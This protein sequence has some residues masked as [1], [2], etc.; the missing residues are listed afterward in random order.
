MASILRRTEAFATLRLQLGKIEDVLGHQRA[1]KRAF[2]DELDE[3]KGYRLQHVDDPAGDTGVSASIIAHDAELA[4][5]FSLALQ[6]EGLDVATIYNDGFPDRH[7]YSYWDGIL[8]KRSPHPSGYP[9]KDPNY[10]GNEYIF[11]AIEAGAKG[12]LLKD[13]SRD[14]LFDAVRAVHRG[15]SLIEPGVASRLLDR[16]AQLSRQ[17]NEPGPSDILS[18]R[19]IEVLQLMATGSA[20]KGIAASLSVSESTVKTH[21]ANIFQKLDVNHRT[22]AVTQ[23]LQRGIIKL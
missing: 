1:L 20:N 21:V 4:R 3:A 6:A 11:D 23:A 10:K 19:E 2:L 8:A 12:Y 22:E 13:A 18:A 14:A 16:L 9:W 7:I 15:E 17:G 5:G